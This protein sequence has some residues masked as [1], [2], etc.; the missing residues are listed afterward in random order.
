MKRLLPLSV[1][2]AV[3][4]AL[5]LVAASAALARRGADDASAPSAAPP[6]PTQGSGNAAAGP[7]S[8][9]GLAEPVDLEAL[10]KRYEALREE[11]FQS[12]ARAAA[13]GDAVYSSRLRIY[14][15]YGAGRFYHVRRATV[16][17]DGV[18]VFDDTGGVVAAD[19]APRF[20]GFVAPG[21]HV[22]AVRLEAQA[23]DDD[24]FV[25][26]SEDTFTVDVPPRR[27]LVLRGRADDEGD[28]AYQW[29]KNARGAYKLRLDVVAEALEEAKG[30]R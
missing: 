4:A 17:V 30:G 8:A 18:N 14:L 12:R 13:V 6:S 3:P 26:T 5:A 2:I 29:K 7:A 16:R 20:E 24:R 25:Y 1:A 23:K 28:I 10:R 21:R 27:T 11:L 22:V 19:D 15:R 9:P